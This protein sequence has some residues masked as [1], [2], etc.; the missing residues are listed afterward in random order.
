MVGTRGT[1]VY[2]LRPLNLNETFSAAMSVIRHSP[3]AAL[4]VPFAAGAVM[5][6]L[7]VTTTLL[8][9]S[10]LN[11]MMTD[12]GAYEDQEIALAAVSDAMFLAVSLITSFF[13]I[14]I[15]VAASALLIIPALRSGAGLTTRFGEALRLSP[16]TWGWLLLHC[17]LLSLI[18]MVVMVVGTF[19]SVLLMVLTMFVGAVIIVPAAL[20]ATVW[21]STA[22]LHAPMVIIS[23][24]RNA[25]SAVVRSFQLN[26]GL[27]WRN[28]GTVA[29]LWLMVSII[30]IIAAFPVGMITGFA[31]SQPWDEAPAEGL[32]VWLMLGMHLV[33][34]VVNAI[35]I[36][37]MGAGAAMIHISS[38]I[39][40]EALDVRL[41]RAAAR[42]DDADAALLAEAWRAP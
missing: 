31:G 24:R 26:R 9:P 10:P 27:W 41:S 34:N 2:P 6:V 13:A 7:T 23:E 16:A 30:V 17:A 25:F 19:L 36:A 11:Q 32:T 18:V 21:A 15:W 14:M 1:N 8:M 39:R 4:G 5:L 29:L 20:L 38:R 12:P 37:L 42:A 22:V 33:E 35:G 3:R 40:Q 28:M